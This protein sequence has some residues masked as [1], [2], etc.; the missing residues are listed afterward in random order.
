MDDRRLTQ[1][2]QKAGPATSQPGGSYS[3]AI[4]N[5]PVAAFY[6]MNHR[7]PPRTIVVRGAGF[8]VEELELMVR[9]TLTLI[10]DGC[11]AEYQEPQQV[12]R[13]S[14]TK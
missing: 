10:C 3:P 14:S 9:I 12:R 2:Q 7:R 13:A 11:G 6:Q 1:R 8:T 4:G 5:Q